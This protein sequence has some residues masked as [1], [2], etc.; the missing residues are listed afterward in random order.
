MNNKTGFKERI[1]ALPIKTNWMKLYIFIILPVLII[2]MC[3]ATAN[4]LAEFNNFLAITAGAAGIIFTALTMVFLIKTK[5]TGYYFNLVLLAAPTFIITYLYK[6]VYK[7]DAIDGI[8]ILMLLIYVMPWSL[9]NIAYFYKRRFI[10]F[11]KFIITKETEN[12]TVIEYC[13]DALKQLKKNVYIQKTESFYRPTFWFKIFIFY[14][15][16][17]GAAVN[18]LSIILLWSDSI[19]ENIV[20][21]ILSAFTVFTYI[22]ARKLLKTGFVLL[23]INFAMAIIGYFI[24]MLTYAS[25]SG[26]SLF[27]IVNIIVAVLISIGPVLNIIYFYKRRSLFTG[28]EELPDDM[29]RR[30]VIVKN[31]KPD[32]AQTE[33]LKKVETGQAEMIKHEK[34]KPKGWDLLPVK[35]QWA[36]FYSYALMPIS[37][38]IAVLIFVGYLL[39]MILDFSSYWYVLISAVMLALV[40]AVFIMFTKYKKAG[41]Y[42]NIILLLS[43]CAAGAYCIAEPISGKILHF[44]AGLVLFLAIWG[45]PNIAY[46]RLRKDVFFNNKA[47]EDNDISDKKD[48]K[49]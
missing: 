48:L 18:F 21:I 4:Q 31:T 16:P 9:F 35:T 19:I 14:L 44:I 37:I 8:G 29:K 32:N 39:N 38:V 7:A 30:T 28:D 45:V 2:A 5:K 3:I 20:I 23:I 12:G 26:E 27:I 6:F 34:I 15:L 40:I 43:E 41:Y 46:F 47:E 25:Q 42:L 11:E 36:K 49:E 24:Y 10:F 1:K 33:A 22:Y 17:I 13:E